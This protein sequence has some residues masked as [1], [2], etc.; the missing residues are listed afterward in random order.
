MALMAFLE[1]EPPNL[2]H[3]VERGNPAILTEKSRTL[4]CPALLFS[5]FGKMHKNF[6]PLSPQLA[7]NYSVRHNQSSAPQ[8]YRVVS[9]LCPK[10][11]HSHPVQATGQDL[12]NRSKGLR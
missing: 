5:H 4:R 12:Q 11:R 10:L 3:P 1:Q 9:A 8:N 2:D 6:W 7:G